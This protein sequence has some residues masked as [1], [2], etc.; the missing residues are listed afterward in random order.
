MTGETDSGITFGATIRADNAPGGQGGTD[1]QTEGSV[2]VS[3]SLGHA[4]LRRHQRRRRAVG[5][6]RPGDFS[7]TGLG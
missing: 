7:L 2:F 4:D 5:R 3:G 1:G 6:R